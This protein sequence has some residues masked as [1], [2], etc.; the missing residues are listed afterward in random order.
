MSGFYIRYGRR[1]SS[2]VD[3]AGSFGFVDGKGVALV[4]PL[5]LC[6]SRM[7]WQEV[8]EAATVFRW[9]ASH[10]GEIGPAPRG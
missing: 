8:I 10:R 4:P 9:S 7:D 3:E 6:F 1:A 2:R 5:Q